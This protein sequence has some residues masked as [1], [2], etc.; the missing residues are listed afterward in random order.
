MREAR[1]RFEKLKDACVKARYSRRYRI[2]SEEP[3]WLGDRAEKLGRVVRQVCA[4]R[5]VTLRRA[6]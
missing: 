2:T 1:A 4:E 5:I 6:A 3:T